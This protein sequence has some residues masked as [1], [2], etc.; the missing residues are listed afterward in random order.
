MRCKGGGGSL[1]YRDVGNVGGNYAAM[2][3]LGSGWRG[4]E[5][6][7]IVVVGEEASLQ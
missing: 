5:A 1:N 2:I 4:G 6:A 3:V 7:V